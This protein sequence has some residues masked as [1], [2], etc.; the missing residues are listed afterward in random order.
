MRHPFELEISELESINLKIQKI[1]D[2]EAEKLAGG[3][4]ATTM[5]TGEEGGGDPTTMATGEE[6][7]IDFSFT[8]AAI[9]EEG[10]ST[11]AFCEEGGCFFPLPSTPKRPLPPINC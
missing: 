9:G 3:L 2:E 5:A 10:G 1:S 11:R 8:S 4:L 7:G 6:G